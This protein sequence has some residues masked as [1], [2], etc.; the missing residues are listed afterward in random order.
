[1]LL[2]WLLSYEF[3]IL[4][5]ESQSC[6]CLGVELWLCLMRRFL[7]FQR[8]SGG[9]SVGSCEPP[10]LTAAAN[11]NTPYCAEH[12][13]FSRLLVASCSSSELSE[14][15]PTKIKPGLMNVV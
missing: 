12:T 9:R 6:S 5:Y 14:R 1:M 10:F 8:E 7:L 4:L 11:K 3:S 15:L 2:S 13:I